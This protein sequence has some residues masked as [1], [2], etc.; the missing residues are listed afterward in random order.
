MKLKYKQETQVRK[1]LVVCATQL[2]GGLLLKK[3]KYLEA[4]LN[5][6]EIFLHSC[7]CKKI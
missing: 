1:C 5:N 7:S 6:F 4:M 3:L 2:A